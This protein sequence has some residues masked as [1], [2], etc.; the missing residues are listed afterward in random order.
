[1][2][3]MEPPSGTA[4]NE[5]LS[6][7]KPYFAGSSGPQPTTSTNPVQTTTTTTPTSTPTGTD[8]AQRWGQCGGNGWTGPTTCASP[9]TCQKVNDWYSQCL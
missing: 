2:Y 5:Y 1:M 8:A 3:N 7:L 9:Y 4:Y 6:L